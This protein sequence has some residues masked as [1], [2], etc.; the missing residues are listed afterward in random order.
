M[1]G[2]F[3]H[4]MLG[5]TPSIATMPLHAGRAGKRLDVGPEDGEALS[6][7]LLGDIWIAAESRTHYARRCTYSWEYRTDK[8]AQ[9]VAYVDGV[10]QALGS[11]WEKALRLAVGDLAE[12][13]V[14]PRGS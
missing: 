6:P 2:L 10:R 12:E 13:F 14:V 9:Y 5:L 1:D 8:Q 7:L 3:R 11:S 4:V